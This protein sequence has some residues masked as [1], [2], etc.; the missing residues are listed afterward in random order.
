MTELINAA[1]YRHLV[2]SNETDDTRELLVS[3]INALGG[4]CW[5][6]TNNRNR[7]GALLLRGLSAY[8]A[9]D[10]GLARIFAHQVIYLA[11]VTV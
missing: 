7:C 3:V 4:V 9:G 1:D 2:F 10:L 6:S 8:Q 11:G 5:P